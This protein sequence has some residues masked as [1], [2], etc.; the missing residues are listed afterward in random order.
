MLGA[1][2]ELSHPVES[3]GGMT[4]AM[5][6]LGIF[7]TVRIRAMLCLNRQTMESPKAAPTA[8]KPC[9]L[10]EPSGAGGLWGLA[11]ENTADIGPR[12]SLALII[13]AICSSLMNGWNDYLSVLTLLLEAAMLS[14]PTL[15]ASMAAI[16]YRITMKSSLRYPRAARD[17]T[18]RASILSL[19]AIA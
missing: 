16:G 12:T 1:C 14:E 4:S 5:W 18:S 7:S 17:V 3:G 15:Y 10:G 9:Q 11:A 6:S 13:L 8:P 2:F 19:H